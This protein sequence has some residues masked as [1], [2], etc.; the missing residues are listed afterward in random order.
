MG[1]LCY[2]PFSLI[3]LNLRADY[4][5]VI[6]CPLGRITLAEAVDNSLLRTDQNGLIQLST[7]S[8]QLWVKVE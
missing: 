8:E 7:G 6:S 2:V 5:G 1:I 3:V 4:S